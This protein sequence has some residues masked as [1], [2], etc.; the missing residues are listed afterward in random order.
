MDLGPTTARRA[1]GRFG[2]CLLLAAGVGG[3]AGAGARTLQETVELA[4]QTNPEVGVV[5]ADREAVNHELRQAR[6]EYFPSVDLRAAAGPEFTNSPTTR[7]RGDPDDRDETLLRL[8]SQLTISQMLFDGFA[9]RSEIDRQLARVDS[10]A[11]R[12]AE[13]AEFIGL[14]AIEAHLEVLRNRAIVELAEQNVAEHRRILGQ[15]RELEREGRGTIADVRQT[16]SRLAAAEAALSAAIGNLRDARATYI[17]RVS[18]P[19]AD[20]SEP[21]APYIAL[22]ESDEA[23][24]RRAAFGNP[25]VLI[26]DADIETAKAELRGSRAGFYPRLDL[27]LGA[28]ANENLDGVEGGDIDA[29]ALVVLRYNLFRGGGDIAREREAFFR[30][31]EAR[32]QLARARRNAE[33]DARLSY[34]ALKTAQARVDNLRAEAEAQRSTRDAYAQQFVVGRRDLL[35]LLDSEN[36]LFLA[37]TDLVTAE[38]TEIF[39]VY[40]VLAV[41]GELLMTLEVDAPKEAI[42]IYRQR[43]E[44]IHERPPDAGQS[45]APAGAG[46]AAERRPRAGQTTVLP[47]G[48]G[49]R[50]GGSF[51]RWQS[52]TDTLNADR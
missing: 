19:P 34:N 27:E 49:G 30:L 7:A 48:S 1:A 41:I 25:T 37:R 14:D 10:A 38:V 21:T 31:K 17:A 18:V 28:G 42:N 45:Q 24:A 43:R 3:A 6:A 13:A 36:Q 9:T 33:E 12:V 16:E 20:L 44:S 46:S 52:I 39:A 23:A 11:Y 35:D 51:E 40:R 4:V 15:V 5:E 47:A 2:L 26:A 8:E 50:R 32:Q 22:P 29:Q